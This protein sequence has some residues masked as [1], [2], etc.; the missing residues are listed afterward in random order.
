MTSLKKMTKKFPHST[1]FVI[2]HKA[3]VYIHK[4]YVFEGRNTVV[5][6][7]MLVSRFLPS[8]ISNCKQNLVFVA[9]F[10]FILEFYLDCL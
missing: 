3:K 6:R 9:F 7:N 5:P 8:R 10:A 2:I 1:D 4:H